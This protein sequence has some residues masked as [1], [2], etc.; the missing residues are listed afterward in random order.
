MA[1]KFKDLGKITRKKLE[2]SFGSELARVM[3]EK[4]QQNRDLKDIK[5][6]KR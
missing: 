6:I 3:K 2:P 1:N 5:E 4:A